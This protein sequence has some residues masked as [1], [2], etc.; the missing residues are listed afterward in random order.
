MSASL[1]ELG[2][3]SSSFLLCFRPSFS[4][5]FF[6]SCRMIRLKLVP[7]EPSFVGPITPVKRGYRILALAGSGV[8]FAVAN[9]M[10]VV[11]RFDDGDRDVRLVTND[12]IGSIG[13]A[14]SDKLAVHDTR[15]S[16]T[17]G[18]GH[19]HRDGTSARHCWAIRSPFCLLKL[20]LRCVV[21]TAHTNIDLW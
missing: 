3:E 2:Q 5:H 19:S 21:V 4:G 15:P 16:R 12:V 18:A 1:L 7:F 10:V 8:T 17:G 6:F 14:A 20:L 9:A 13:L 11:C